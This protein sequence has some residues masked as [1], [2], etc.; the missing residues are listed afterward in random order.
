MRRYL[1]DDHKQLLEIAMT[2]LPCASK[3]AALRQQLAAASGRGA[4]TSD[5]ADASSDTLPRDTAE[6]LIRY[7]GVDARTVWG[8]ITGRRYEFATG[9]TIVSV[10]A[11]DAEDLL[12]SKTFKRLA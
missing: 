5:T 4:V 12:L 10:S 8:R 2:C 1:I 7:M 11:A 3:R 6:Y 9:S